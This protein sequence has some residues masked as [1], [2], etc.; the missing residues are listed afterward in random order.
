MTLMKKSSLLLAGLALGTAL[1]ACGGSTPPPAA[2]TSVP[3]APPSAAGAAPTQGTTRVSA[4]DASE[5]ELVSALTAAG[6]DNADRWADEVVEYRPYPADDPNFA[7]LRGELAKY[8]PSQ[9][10]VDRIVSTLTP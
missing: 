7:K 4:N 1:V 8:N 2:P 10:T 6:V 5:E 3:V 9:E